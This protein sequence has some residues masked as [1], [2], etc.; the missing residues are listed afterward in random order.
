MKHIHHFE[1]FTNS[2]NESYG[3]KGV[4]LLGIY[5]A[6][7]HKNFVDDLKRYQLQGFAFGNLKDPKIW[8]AYTKRSDG[9]NTFFLFETDDDYMLALISKD[10]KKFIAAVPYVKMR[11]IP[12]SEFFDLI[13]P[14][15]VN[16]K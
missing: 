11:D 8:N 6:D 15:W 10:F 1:N 14:G 2:V 3:N 4:E 12:S 16:V 9:P 7:Q 5:K 13:S